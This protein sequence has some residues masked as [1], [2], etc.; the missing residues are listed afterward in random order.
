MRGQYSKNSE[1]KEGKKGANGNGGKN[2]ASVK[3]VVTRNGWTT[4]QSKKRKYE[5]V[6][7]KAAF[8]LTGIPSTVNRD[9]CLQGF[10]IR[11]GESEEEVMESVRAYCL[12]RGITPVFIRSIPVKFDCTRT[13]CRLTIVEED[14]ERVILNSFWPQNIRTRDWTPRP[15]EDKGAEVEDDGQ[16][17]D[18]DEYR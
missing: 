3:K 13:G 8:P 2:G 18:N 6:S 15:R 7:L 4:V 12:D 5:K 11:N 10:R 1:N 14:Y 16:S 17:S 9:V